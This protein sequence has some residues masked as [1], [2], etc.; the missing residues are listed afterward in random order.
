MYAITRT[1]ALTGEAAERK[2]SRLKKDV[3]YGLS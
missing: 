2:I 3:R 1:P